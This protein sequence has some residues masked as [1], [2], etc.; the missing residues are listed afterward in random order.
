M[1][2]NNS[3]LVF[4]VLKTHT[5]TKQRR[6]YVSMKS[7]GR[8]LIETNKALERWKEYCKDVYNCELN[9]DASLLQEEL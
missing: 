5:T 7:D 4:D 1:T 8:V 9:P 2:A 6:E 3:R